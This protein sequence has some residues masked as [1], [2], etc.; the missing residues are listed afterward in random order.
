[1][2]QIK[3]ER[4]FITFVPNN[5][6]RVC[7]KLRGYKMVLCHVTFPFVSGKWAHF[8]KHVSNEIGRQTWR[9]MTVLFESIFFWFNEMSIFFLVDSCGIDNAGRECRNNPSKVTIRSFADASSTAGKFLQF[10]LF[11]GWQ[12]LGW[13]SVLHNLSNYLITTTRSM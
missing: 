12:T 13:R 6:A 3:C 8:I 9:D 5:P 10:F 2:I 1:M 4:I 7:W 11:T